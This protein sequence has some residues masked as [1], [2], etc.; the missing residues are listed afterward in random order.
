MITMRRN[1][2]IRP[3]IPP[4]CP[5]SAEQCQHTD[6]ATR[7][8]CQDP[9]QTAAAILPTTAGLAVESDSPTREEVVPRDVCSEFAFAMIVSIFPIRTP[10]ASPSGINSTS[11]SATVMITV[12]TPRRPP[13][14]D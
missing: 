11:R 10:N 8:D 1:C 7:T 14:L 3:P 6:S 4:I 12:A 2:R 5:A 9:P 13:T